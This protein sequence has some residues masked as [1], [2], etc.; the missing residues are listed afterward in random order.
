MML[1]DI[2]RKVKYYNEPKKFKLPSITKSY[3]N[4][5]ESTVDHT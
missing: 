3:L 1:D 4:R 2:T 5:N